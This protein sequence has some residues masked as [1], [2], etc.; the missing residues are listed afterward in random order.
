MNSKTIC[1]ILA[2]LA[3]N[4]I[5]CSYEPTGPNLTPANVLKGHGGFLTGEW[6]RDYSETGD[7]Y[8]DVIRFYSDSSFVLM[9]Y[10]IT[11]DKPES[12]LWYGEYDSL[13]YEVSKD[14]LKLYEYDYYTQERNY[15]Y[16]T[17]IYEF[18]SDTLM[19]YIDGEYMYFRKTANLY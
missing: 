16:E 8:R 11:P 2:I 4:F 7:T 1:I 3:L 10:E 18:M 12:L 5:F 15:W 13:F 9:T 14:T 19:L 17:I 6:Q